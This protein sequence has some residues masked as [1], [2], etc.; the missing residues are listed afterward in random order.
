MQDGF[1][2]GQGSH[3]YTCTARMIEMDVGQK[4]V[5]DIRWIDMF[6]RKRLEQHRH[7]IIDPAINKG[8]API[9]DDQVARVE[10]GPQ[11]ISIDSGNAIVMICHSQV[12]LGHRSPD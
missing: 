12:V 4:Q 2:I 11:Q 8:G 5:V 1:R 7:T 10:I 3:Q 6:F 9:L